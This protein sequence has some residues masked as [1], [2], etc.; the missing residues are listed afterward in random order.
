[1][2]LNYRLRNVSTA[3]C[4]QR[5]SCS[6][7][8]T[9]Q[10][11]SFENRNMNV[12][13]YWIL[14][15]FEV[16]L[17]VALKQVQISLHMKHRGDSPWRTNNLH[18]HFSWNFLHSSVLST[19]HFYSLLCHLCHSVTSSPLRRL[20]ASEASM[21]LLFVPSVCCLLITNQ[22]ILCVTLATSAIATFWHA[23]QP[24]EPAFQSV[25]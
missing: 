21:S 14:V 2:S 24:S 10:M 17:I 12:E 15:G 4:L 22:L 8:L 3:F 7:T 9:T 20:P 16:M 19:S 6:Q 5:K 23:L 1:M 18:V 11:W 13:T 25:Q